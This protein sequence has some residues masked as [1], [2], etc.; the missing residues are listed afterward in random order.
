MR[1]VR[2]YGSEEVLSNPQRPLQI[3]VIGLGRWGINYVRE[4]QSFDGVEV[5]AL[6]DPDPGARARGAEVAAS[7]TA[8]AS[9]EEAFG[10]ELD[11]LILATPSPSHAALALAGLATRAHVLVEKPL[12]TSAA[13]ALRVARA[14][15]ATRRLLVG[16][17][18]VH[19]RVHRWLEEVVAAGTLGEVVSVAA[20]RTSAGAARSSEPAFWALGPHDVCAAL[21][22]IGAPAAKVRA[23]SV[24]ALQ[25]GA[26]V[27]VTFQNGATAQL[28]FARTGSAARTLE[29]RGTAGSAR[30]D[31]SSG[32]AWLLMD[33][34]W[35]EQTV[36]AGPSPLNAQCAHFLDCIRHGTMPRASAEEG[37]AVV[38]ILTAAQASAAAAGAWIH[39]LRASR[40][41]RRSSANVVLP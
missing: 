1:A 36:A 4:L 16:H 35:R 31:E 23:R 19:H 33:G 17:I 21:R 18:T 22:V 25:Q 28:A 27:E 14:P 20:V 5:A 9:A 32:R 11:G 6:V 24:D 39:D 37:V 15:G 7:A 2:G 12:A 10:L 34:E 26:E 38:E 3:A 41:R 30:V 8:L 13:D 40:D 29:V